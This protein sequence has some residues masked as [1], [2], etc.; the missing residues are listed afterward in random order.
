MRGYRKVKRIKPL[1]EKEMIGMLIV[2]SLVE[3]L[4]KYR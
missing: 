1:S 3:K 2:K 4:N